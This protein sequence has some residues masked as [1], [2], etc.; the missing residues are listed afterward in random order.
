MSFLFSPYPA[1]L[2]LRESAHAFFLRCL[3]FL[4]SFRFYSFPL[5]NLSIQLLFIAWS[6]TWESLMW[7]F[8]FFLSSL[9]SCEGIL[10]DFQPPWCEP[11]CQLWNVSF[12]S[13]QIWCHRIR[14]FSS[15]RSCE[16]LEFRAV[17]LSSLCITSRFTFDES[18]ELSQGLVISMMRN[19]VYK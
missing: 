16:E 7:V 11:K 18:Q 5:L 6:A 9:V 12:C 15:N 4:F 2:H 14:E 3:P 13:H 8:G 19:R 17:V 10:G 1:L